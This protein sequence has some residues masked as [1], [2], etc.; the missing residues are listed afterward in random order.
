MLRWF[1]RLVAHPMCNQDWFSETDDDNDEM[2]ASPAA[3][4]FQ[5][6]P[7]RTLKAD[8]ERLAK[9]AFEQGMGTTSIMKSPTLAPTAKISSSREYKRWLGKLPGRVSPS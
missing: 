6:S 5:V 2:T 4:V 1:D 8:Q 3:R 7:R 9:A